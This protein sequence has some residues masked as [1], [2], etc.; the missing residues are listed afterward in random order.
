[1]PASPLPTVEIFVNEPELLPEINQNI[2]QT[3]SAIREEDDLADTQ[4]TRPNDTKLGEDLTEVS[5]D[6]KLPFLI[7]EAKVPEN[8][9]IEESVYTPRII[10]R[11]THLRRSSL[12]RK[13]ARYSCLV[14]FF[15]LFMIMFACIFIYS[16]IKSS[17]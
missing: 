2:S 12:N 13:N 8:P 17:S 16:V 9:V 6:Q 1:V 5:D 3:L 7:V 14:F 15:S 4:L 10:T 11:T